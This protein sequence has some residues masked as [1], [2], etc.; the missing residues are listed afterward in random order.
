[1]FKKLISILLILIFLSSPIF[2]EAELSYKPYGK[3]EFPIWT[4]KLRRAES[5]FFGSLVLTLPITSL[6][7]NLCENN[8]LITKIDRPMDKFLYQLG[9][10]SG[11]SLCISTADWI[12][13][14]FS[15]DN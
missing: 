7:W 14:E 3:D 6:V 11:L 2:A 9:V 12:I 5:I 15:R 8:G 13:G 10:A 1:M 4:M